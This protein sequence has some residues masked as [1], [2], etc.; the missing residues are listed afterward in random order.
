MKK[1]LTLILILFQTIVIGSEPPKPGNY[2][3]QPS[4]PN[5]AQRIGDYPFPTNPMTDRARGYLLQG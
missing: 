4:F 2:V 5:S 3:E 1:L